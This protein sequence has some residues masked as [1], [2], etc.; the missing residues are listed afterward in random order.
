MVALMNTTHVGSPTLPHLSHTSPAPNA[1]RAAFLPENYVHEAAVSAFC[2]SPS[3][4]THL[5]TQQTRNSE[6]EL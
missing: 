5:S 2:S 6:P 1:I 3:S 4:L